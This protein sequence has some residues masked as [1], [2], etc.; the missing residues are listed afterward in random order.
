MK[1]T[2]DNVGNRI[3]KIIT[4][5][6]G[7]HV[8]GYEYDALYR[9]T[10]E[11]YPDTHDVV[12]T[13]DQNGNRLTR[14]EN[15]NTITSV[16]DNADQLLTAGPLDFSWDGNGNQ[17]QKIDH[18]QGDATTTYAYDYENLLSQITFPDTSTESYVY[19]GDGLRVKKTT[20]GI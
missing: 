7:Q 14:T 1:I 9:L 11:V 13:Y 18:S 10:R 8:W 5:G 3:S 20:G 2:H 19:D 17:V 16:Y 12:Y 4:D 15:G 6:Q